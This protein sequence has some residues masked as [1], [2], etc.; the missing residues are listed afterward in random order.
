MPEFV[1]N[2]RQAISRLAAAAALFGMTAEAPLAPA[3]ELPDRSLLDADADAYWA[4]IREEQFLLPANRVFLNTG[5]LGVVARPVLEAVANYLH[6]SAELEHGGLQA[7]QYPRW[8]YEALDEERA[9]LADFVGCSKH[10]LA[11]THN[12][13]EAMSIIAGGMPLEAGAEVLLTDQEHPSGRG[14]WHVREARGELTTRV[15]ALPLPPE[16]PG[17]LVD[18]VISAIGPKTRVL[19]ISGITS[20][21]GLLM[22]V[23]EICE[24]ARRR[25]VI[26]V[27]DGAHMTG[28]V[29]YRIDEMDCDYFAGSPHKW[30]FAPA[31]S[32]LLYVREERLE[33]HYPVIATAGWDDHSLGAGR[34]TRFGTNN[35]AIVEGFIAGLRFARDLGHENVYRRIH[36]LAIE[37]Y[38]RAR[39]LPYVEM[40]SPEDD[41]MYGSLVTFRLNLPAPKLERLW[42]LCNERRIW[43]TGASQLRIST[44]I[45]TRRS[46]LE[47]FFETLAEAAA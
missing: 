22:P 1:L 29:P 11:I 27:V 47:L 30:L 46:D 4:R 34:F 21:T 8:G 6:R 35:R 7:E 32:G 43:T 33:G 25:G 18:V 9:E 42:A 23:R 5:S 12:A 10:E 40:L 37:T 45:H 39:G 28:Q 3:A 44:H 19:S 38:R 24:A 16:S 26:T 15:V 36:Q 31:G 13:T 2:R 20:P 17:Q 41:R 14:P